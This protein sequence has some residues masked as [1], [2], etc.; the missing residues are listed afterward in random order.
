[1]PRCCAVIADPVSSSVH[2]YCEIDHPDEV[3]GKKAAAE[4]AEAAFAAAR[5]KDGKPKV[6]TYTKKGR[7]TQQQI[8]TL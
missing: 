2:V 1:M 7:L 3:A 4:A 6:S 5:P 8:D